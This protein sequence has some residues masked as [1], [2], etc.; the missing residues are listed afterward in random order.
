MVPEY[1]DGDEDNIASMSDT[2]LMAAAKGYLDINCAHCHRPEGNA[3][4]TGLKL[5]YWRSYDEDAGFSHGTCKSPVAYGGGTL[6]FDVVPGNPEE[7]I[8]H[9]RME[10]NDPGDRMPEIGRSLSHDEGVALI[11]EWIKRLPAASC[12]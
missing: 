2:E 9:F 1:Q 8:L 4:N 11:N 5:E 10:T 7:S 3:S 12:S 6:G